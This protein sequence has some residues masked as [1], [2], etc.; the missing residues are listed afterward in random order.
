MQQVRIEA[1]PRTA[2]RG[3]ALR[4]LRNAG[5]VPSVVYGYGEPAQS[6]SVDMKE[7]WTALVK[8]GAEHAL[9]NL[10]W[11]GEQSL[12]IIKDVQ[13]DPVRHRLLHVD[14]MKVRADKPITM[15]TAIHLEG[16]PIGVRDD[17]GIL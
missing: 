17:G 1:E 5:K 16:E 9:I 2:H 10:N 15:E 13:R 14:F 11:G 12:A 6:I 7:L 3:S 8:R 4:A